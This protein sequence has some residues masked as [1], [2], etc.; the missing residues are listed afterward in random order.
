[1]K[2]MLFIWMKFGMEL[3]NVKKLFMENIISIPLIVHI[4]GVKPR[5][6]RIL[7]KFSK[8]YSQDYTFII[9]YD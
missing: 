6:S 9:D 1:M 8:L 7:F 5:F 2:Y 3:D 4:V